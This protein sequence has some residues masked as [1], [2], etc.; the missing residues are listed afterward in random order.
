MP[1]FDAVLFD[2][3]G[4]ILDTLADIG[5]SM[6]RVLISFGFAPHPLDAYRYF[7]GEGSAVLV[8]KAL[9]EAARKPDII[10]KCLRGYQE[11]YGRHWRVHTRL[12]PGI[13][14]LLDALVRKTIRMAILSN[15]FHEF[16]LQCYEHF[17]GRWPFDPVLGIREGIPRK[18]D[19]TAALEVAEYLGL[20]P[21]RI[22]YVGDT[23]VD[24][25]TAV[26]AGMFPVGVL[27]GFRGREE[28]LTNGARFLAEHPVQILE[29]FFDA[30]SKGADLTEGT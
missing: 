11:D 15:K 26:S 21:S 20:S 16:T 9:P 27:W 19:P 3:D 29:T 10:Q 6:N 30:P 8:E 18:P 13:A 5:E 1:T 12:Y 17:F 28:L 22:L 25:Q 23:A 2:M 4:T 7:V 14:E 24:M